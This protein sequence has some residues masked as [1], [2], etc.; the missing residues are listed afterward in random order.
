MGNAVGGAAAG[1]GANSEAAAAQKR[2]ALQELGLEA[3]MAPK[4]KGAEAGVLAGDVSHT[5]RKTPRVDAIMEKRL[6]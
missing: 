4:Q 5:G 2:H 3:P 1:P 6:G